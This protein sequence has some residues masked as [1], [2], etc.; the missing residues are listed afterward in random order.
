MKANNKYL[1]LL[2]LFFAGAWFWKQSSLKNP[3]DEFILDG[4]HTPKKPCINVLNE[5]F[6]KGIDSVK[7][8]D[9]LIPEFYHF[10]KNDSD[11]V[12]KFREV[13]LFALDDSSNER[14]I[15][16]FENCLR[17]SLLDSN[18]VLSL[19]G[20]YLAGYK[21]KIRQSLASK[22]EFKNYDADILANC[23]M[24]RMNNHITMGEYL[25]YDYLEVE[26]LKQAMLQCMEEAKK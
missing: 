7:V 11:K 3:Q 25:A 6:G 12:I 2:A 13:G 10:I 26:K 1:I 9:C 8:C 14:F 22:K 4:I 15:P 20:E 21:N 16:L 24:D 17:S 5:M 19:S 23:I 18:Y